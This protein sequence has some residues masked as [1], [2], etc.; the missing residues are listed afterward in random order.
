MKKTIATLL[1]FCIMIGLSAC[2]STS[3]NNPSAAKDFIDIGFFE[4]KIKLDSIRDIEGNLFIIEDDGQILELG[5]NYTKA[6]LTA[7]RICQ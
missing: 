2:G 4:E 3:S 7:D 5:K 6:A 1:C